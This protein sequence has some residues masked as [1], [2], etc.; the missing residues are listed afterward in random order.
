MAGAAELRT[1]TDMFVTFYQELLQ[2]KETVP[3]CYSPS[4]NAML[5]LNPWDATRKTLRTEKSPPEI[6]EPV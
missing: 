5:G 1:D 3:R 6:V 2:A 4:K